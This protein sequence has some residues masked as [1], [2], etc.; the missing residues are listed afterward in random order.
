LI[1]WRAGRPGDA[2]ERYADVRKSKEELDWSAV[3]GIEEMCADSWRFAA[4]G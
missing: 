3:C 2:A 1:L 4:G